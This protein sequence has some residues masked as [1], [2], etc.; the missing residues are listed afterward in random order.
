[1][2]QVAQ[3]PSARQR[4]SCP[5]P[6]P[7]LPP[8]LAPTPPPSPRRG[9]EA[10]TLQV[11]AEPPFEGL[12]APEGHVPH[13][14]LQ[15]IGSRQTL[16]W[17]AARGSGRPCPAKMSGDPSENLSL[18]EKRREGVR[19]GEG[20]R[21]N[22]QRDKASPGPR[23]AEARPHSQREEEAGPQNR[24]PSG[25]PEQLSPAPT[26][27]GCPAVPGLLW[28]R[29]PSRFIHLPLQRAGPSRCERK[30]GESC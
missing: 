1:M 20:Q 8:R 23:A 25:N 24:G 14:R 22:A 3:G 13:P 18:A 28:G 17:R 4:C 12:S 5:Q 6:L 16:A 19:L 30:S 10:P 27:T 29:D 11:W 15:L 2:E 9:S 7:I 26:Q 21:A